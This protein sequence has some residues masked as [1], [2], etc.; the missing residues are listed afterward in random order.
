M[1][2]VEVLGSGRVGLFR[3]CEDFGCF[4]EREEAAGGFWRKRWR[5][6]T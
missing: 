2:R 6:L 1:V 5:D 3:P 4:F